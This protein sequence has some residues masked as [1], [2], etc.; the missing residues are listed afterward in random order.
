MRLTARE[1]ELL[2]RCAQFVLAGEWPWED[3]SE[4]EETRNKAALDRACEKLAGVP[5]TEKKS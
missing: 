4:A 2:A 1:K 3:E 5:L